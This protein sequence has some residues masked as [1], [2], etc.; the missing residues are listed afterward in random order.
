MKQTVM[1]GGSTKDF[2]TAPE[3]A[4]VEAATAVE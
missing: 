4:V 1:G 2:E 3:V